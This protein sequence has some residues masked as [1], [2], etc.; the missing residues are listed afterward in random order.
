MM[1]PVHQ[2]RPL[3]ESEIREA[4][5]LFRATLHLSPVTDEEWA[6]LSGY[7]ESTRPF[8]AFLDGELIGTATSSAV[9]LAVPGGVTSAAAVTMVGVRADRTRRGALTA[10]MRAQLADVLDRGESV[11]ILHASEAVIYARFGYGPATRARTVSLDP[12]V[13]AMR[14][15]APSGGRV[16]VVDVADAA[17]ILP[18]IYRRVGL[19][20][21]GMISRDESWWGRAT[22]TDEYRVILVHVGQ[23]GQEDGYAVYEPI[24]GDLRIGD[25]SCTLQV[26][27]FQAADAVAA[28]ELWRFLLAVDLV[29]GVRVVRRPLD[30]PLEWWLT[31]RRSVQVSTMD[32]DIWLR[33]VDVPAALAARTFGGTEPVVIEIRDKILPRNSGNYRIGPD[34]VS[35]SDRPA[36]LAMDVDALGAAYLG[37]VT[38]STLAAANR[39]DVLDPAALGIADRIFATG[40]IPW[41]GT[42]F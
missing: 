22:R 33:P 34:G 30:E 23:N 25:Y 12:R 31:D 27:D 13:A 20:R 7:F 29:N 16:R 26:R 19:A 6:K 28:A 10:M 1:R 38:L 2:V 3:A 17:K 32:D 4:N 41:C 24:K 21:P 40:R 5:N 42:G 11:A 36:Q 14:A 18:E 39:V 35:R 37:D 8:G 9:S 15:D